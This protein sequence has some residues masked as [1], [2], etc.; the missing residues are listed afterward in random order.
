MNWAPRRIGSGRPRQVAA[1]DRAEQ[2]S[3]NAGD[4][5]DDHRA[6][7]AV[8]LRRG[9]AELPHP[10]HIEQDV[11]E[12]PV[13]PG[14]ADDGPPAPVD[15]HGDGA[16]G[17]QQ[18]Q[19]LHARRQ[20]REEALH[21]DAPAREQQ[22]R[23][24]Q[25]RAAPHDQRDEPEVAAEPAQERSKAPQTGIAAAAGQASLVT[26]AHQGPARGA[27]DRTAG[28]ACEHQGSA[29]CAA[30]NTGLDYMPPA[31]EPLRVRRPGRV[32]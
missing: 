14:R 3:A 12:A 26:H 32:Y 19:A 18:E 31:D 5:V 13:Q 9:G 30:A 2:E 28:L 7:R 11:E 10:Q 29:L 23:D 15:E 21:A 1:G 4:R 16:A 6:A 25:G 8:H 24:V 20:Q 22:R 17:A 27:D